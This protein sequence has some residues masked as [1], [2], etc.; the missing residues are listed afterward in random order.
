MRN[1]LFSLLALSAS[2]SSPATDSAHLAS[3]SE[4][5]PVQTVGQRTTGPA[6]T[7]AMAYDFSRPAATYPMPAELAELSGIA[8]AGTTHITGVEDET[9]NLYEYNLSTK[10]VDRVI[11]FGGS[12]DYE[13]LAR[14]GSDWFIMRSDGKLFRY[15][16]GK[17]EE[18]ET[19]LSFANETEGLTYDAASKTLLVACKAEPGA[20]LSY[21]QRAIYRL[22]PGTFKAEAKPAYVLDV[23]AI[24]NSSPAAEAEKSG[25]KGKK[26]SSGKSFSPSAVAVHPVTQHVFVLSAKQNGIVE[27]DQNGQLLAAQP[28]PA[29]LFPQAE[30]LAFAPNG[31]L[32]VATEAKDADQ[33]MIHLF[34]V[35]AR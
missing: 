19:G 15:A 1:L 32:Y 12:G 30:G 14:V 7:A 21:S 6:P 8:L 35:Q 29:D 25:K 2:C 16:G 5:L 23:D 34:R 4:D 18:F 22:Q 20:G 17:T 13:D 9:G 11:P 26:K 10:K 3:A 28:L 33:A 31:D 24:R 27:L